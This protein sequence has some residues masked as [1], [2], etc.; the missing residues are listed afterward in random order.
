MVHI[1]H[2]SLK[3]TS[4]SHQRGL[5]RTTPAA[6]DHF[7]DQNRARI[8]A[9]RTMQTLSKL[10]LCILVALSERDISR[11]RWNHITHDVQICHRLSSL[12]RNRFPEDVS[13]DSVAG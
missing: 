6:L 2:H 4:E 10:H 5:V 13:L 11:S 8:G 3:F 12:G 1:I 7:A 9:Q